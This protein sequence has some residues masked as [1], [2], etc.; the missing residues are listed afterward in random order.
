[1]YVH[2]CV[3]VCVCVCVRARSRI[4][5]HVHM[6]EYTGG[7]QRTTCESRCSPSTL[8]DPG[9]KLSS[10]P[11][12]LM[13]H[14]IDPVVNFP[15]VCLLD[16]HLYQHIRLFLFLWCF[17]T[18]SWVLSLHTFLLKEFL[19]FDSTPLGTYLFNLSCIDSYFRKD[20]SRLKGCSPGGLFIFCLSH[21]VAVLV[22]V[23]QFPIIQLAGRTMCAEVPEL[24]RLGD[25]VLSALTHG[26]SEMMKHHQINSSTQCYWATRLSDLQN[27]PHPVD[28]FHTLTGTS[29]IL[30]SFLPS[31]LPSP[32]L[33]FYWS[34][35]V[36]GG[37]WKGKL[38]GGRGRQSCTPQGS[39][40]RDKSWV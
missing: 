2:V 39:H 3:C 8:L 21:L 17:I 10:K 38:L 29:I 32:A 30:P 14:V 36:S 27:V 37:T 12:Y 23:K 35:I 33:L 22:S 25:T 24:Q 9:I 18:L 26:D 19:R 4:W 6:P 11:L 31:F 34:F 13:G 20:R 5:M 16:F 15:T 28:I 1:M 40:R 7:Y